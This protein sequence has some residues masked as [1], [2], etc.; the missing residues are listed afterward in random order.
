MVFLLIP[1]GRGTPLYR[2]RAPLVVEIPARG[3]GR[4][5]AIRGGDFLHPL[6]SAKLEV[7]RGCPFMFLN[8]GTVDPAP[9]E[10][11]PSREFSGDEVLYDP[12]LHEGRERVLVDPEKFRNEHP[13]EVPPGYVDTL[14]KWYSVKFTYPDHNRIFVLPGW[15]ISFQKH[16][17]RTEFWTIRSGRPIIVAGKKV[18]YE[19]PGG[20]RFAIPAGTIHAVINP[21][22]DR[23]V[24]LE[25][26]YEGHFDEE[27]IERVFNPNA[28]GR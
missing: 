26:R 19:V 1:P 5:A 14:A 6:P 27:D 24:F 12:Y 18:S 10:V 28:Y 20:T 11:H 17:L 3:E 8:V 4:I 16:E 13:E 23:L 22:A 9:V 25:E 7:P 2:A 21:H 15:G